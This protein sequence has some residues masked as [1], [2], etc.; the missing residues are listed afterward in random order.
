MLSTC[1]FLPPM[2]LPNLALLSNLSAFGVFASVFLALGVTGEGFLGMTPD[3]SKCKPPCTGS[4]LHPS[5]TE[6]YKLDDIPIVLGLVMVGFAGHAVFPTI[7]ND[8]AEKKHYNS[9]V[10][11]T[12]I[13]VILSYVGIAAAGYLM[14]GNSA[15]EQITLNLGQSPISQCIIWV[16]ITNPIC[17][18]PLDMAPIAFGL[19]SFF[20]ITF[21]LHYNSWLYT[22]VSISL[23]T[24]LVFLSLALVVAIPS[25]SLLVSL[26][27]SVGS[28]TICVTFPCAC[29]L[30]LFW[31]EISLPTKVP[32]PHVALSS[33]SLPYHP[34]PPH[35]LFTPNPA[36][37]EC[38]LHHY[39][40][41][42]H[43][44]WGLQRPCAWRRSLGGH[45][46]SPPKIYWFNTLYYDIISVLLV[47]HCF[48]L[49]GNLK[50]VRLLR[51]QEVGELYWATGNSG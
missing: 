49:V 32:P 20:A 22:F 14:F 47:H 31:G 6:L 1:I 16:I 41:R 13:F 40:G 27:G 19:E 34:V 42:G 43:G 11:V 9:M 26:L 23:R 7:K 5:P 4:I 28:F 30:K 48:S 37:S 24:M 51:A 3:M 33:A 12:Y 17:K 2:W 50:C 36:G 21:K 39:R 29:F 46:R 15:D 35:P 25:F 38:H 10:D 45:V 44:R 18:Y 8:M